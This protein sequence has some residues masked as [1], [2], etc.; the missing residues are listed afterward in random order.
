MGYNIVLQEYFMQSVYSIPI[1]L[2]GITFALIGIMLIIKAKKKEKSTILLIIFFLAISFFVFIS[3][4]N[5]FGITTIKMYLDYK[6]YDYSYYEGIITASSGKNGL[7]GT[8][9]SLNENSFIV[10][11]TMKSDMRVN[12]GNLC[13]I[14]YATKSRVVVDYEIV[15]GD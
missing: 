14:V 9:I 7:A 4:L 12:K 13:K 1:L 15:N 6:N 3:Y 8:T 5:N 2:I 10:N 11:D